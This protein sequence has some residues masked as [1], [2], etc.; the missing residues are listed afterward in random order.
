[1]KVWWCVIDVS[2][3]RKRRAHN[4]IYQRIVPRLYRSVGLTVFNS[5]IG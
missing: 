1:M 5:R 2:R 3:M 4:W